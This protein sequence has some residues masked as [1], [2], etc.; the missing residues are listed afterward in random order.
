[1]TPK[2]R[3]FLY[4]TLLPGILKNITYIAAAFWGIFLLTPFSG[5]GQTRFET[6]DINFVFKATETFSDAALADIL[7]LPREKYLPAVQVDVTTR[8]GQLSTDIFIE[9]ALA[10]LRTI[11]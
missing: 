8:K 3:G 10:Y 6:D 11:N 1:M 7:L 4:T 5:F 2:F 9:R